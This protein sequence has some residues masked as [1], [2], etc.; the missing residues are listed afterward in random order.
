MPMAIAD[1]APL[2]T[3]IHGSPGDAGRTFHVAILSE[4]FLVQEVESF[5]F[6]AAALAR[7]LLA[8]SPFR[9]HRDR[10]S[11]TRIDCLSRRSAQ[12]LQALK[13]PPPGFKGNTPF[14]AAFDLKIERIVEGDEVAV[15]ALLLSLNALPTFSAIAV[16]VNSNL[17]A[18]VATGQ[19]AWTTLHAD[20]RR[21]AI[22]ELGHAAFG[23]ADEYAGLLGKPTELPRR[24]DGAERV[25]G[26]VTK[27]KLRA[28]IPWRDLINV[29]DAF[30][31]STVASAPGTCAKVHPNKPLLAAN[32]LGLF[33]GAFTH[34][35]GVFRATANCLMREEANPFCP[36]CDRIV[37]RKLGTGSL[38]PQPQLA[39]SALPFT[40]VVTVPRLT[41]TSEPCI[42]AGYDT[43]SGRI[44]IFA[45]DEVTAQAPKLTSLGDGVIERGWTSVAASDSGGDPILV[46][47][48]LTAGGPA[49]SRLN[50]VIPNSTVTIDREFLGNAPLG[51]SHLSSLRIAFVP[52]LLHYSRLDGA[53]ALERIVGV[54]GVATT[55]LLASSRVR[56][57]V[58]FHPF[59]SSLAS[60][61]LDGLPF[62]VSLD[63]TNGIVRISAV[64]VPLSAA[65]PATLLTDVF[66][67]KPGFL[68]GFSTHCA[69]I[70][71]N[72]V[73]KLVTYSAVTGLAVVWSFRQGG[74]GLDFQDAVRLGRGA[75]TVFD[76]GLPA[77][78]DTAQTSQ[79]WFYNAAL[80]SFVLRRFA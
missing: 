71:V 76:V 15:T 73:P 36:V 9:R 67:S 64:N 48:R 21:I 44:S 26:N 56:S 13:P 59:L 16:I 51:F 68:I 63:A 31:P 61:E 80:K 55:Q 65:S 60:V 69:A 75:A 8:E 35:C 78:G 24:Y 45:L 74:Q 1:V 79:L 11:I 29:T 37:D 5:R 58:P 34:H 47:N 77:L 66:T 43:V 32:A 70:R 22:H 30:L 19:V 18:G 72:D 27:R 3:F 33:E 2:A 28:D 57:A 4:G 42:V 7:T 14:D 6:A 20:G 23:L 52:H 49:I 12:V 46:F 40:H 17:R 54:S 38:V 53:I 50:R 25:E 39:A 10:I 62:I 41:A